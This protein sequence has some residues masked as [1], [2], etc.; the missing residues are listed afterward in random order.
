MP[1]TDNI[2]SFDISSPNSKAQAI[3]ERAKQRRLELY[4]TQEGLPVR[5]G[6]PF[7]IYRQ[8]ERIGK[9]SLEGYH[10]I[11]YALDA[12][13]LQKPWK[14]RCSTTC[15]EVWIEKERGGGNV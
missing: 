6:I 10:H 11:A 15:R 8:F 4:L 2:L 1:L 7:V 14:R 13:Q 5:A 9:F 3:A 12:S